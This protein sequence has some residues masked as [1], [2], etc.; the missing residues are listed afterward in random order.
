MKVDMVGEWNL[1]HYRRQY[2][3]HPGYWIS[4]GKTIEAHG[5]LR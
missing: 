3:W 5:L 2:N 1:R 4:S